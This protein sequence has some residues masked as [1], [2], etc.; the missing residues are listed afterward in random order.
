M[1]EKSPRKHGGFIILLCTFFVGDNMVKSEEA[2]VALCMERQYDVVQRTL[3]R[4][5]EDL[6]SNSA[7]A[8]HF[9]SS[10]RA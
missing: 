1:P 7:S 4:D 3:G 9:G 10:F 6:V 8:L 5:S 2:H